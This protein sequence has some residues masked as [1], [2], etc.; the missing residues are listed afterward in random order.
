MPDLE[1]LPIRYATGDVAAWMDDSACQ[2]GRTSPRL[3]PILGRMQHQ[4]KVQ[5]QTVFPDFL[6]GIADRCPDIARSAVLAEDSPLG[7]DQATMLVVPTA[8]ERAEP[9]SR[10]V[11]QILDEQLAVSPEVRLVGSSELVAY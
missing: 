6:I 11:R 2:C 3:G 8:P 9:V 10:R 4:L 7:Q 5:G 1:F